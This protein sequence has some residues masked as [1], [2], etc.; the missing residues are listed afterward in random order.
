MFAAQPNPLHPKQRRR[1]ARSTSIWLED[2]D[3]TRAS[4]VFTPDEFLA[5]AE[6]SSWDVCDPFDPSCD[7]DAHEWPFAP[8]LADG[9]QVA[10][11]AS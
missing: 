7:H 1:S 8:F 3:G 10:E 6:T 9:P 4:R 5:R 11:Q 2:A